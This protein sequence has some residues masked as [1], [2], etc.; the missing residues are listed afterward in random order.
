M[1]VEKLTKPG[2]TVVDL[3]VGTG[4]SILAAFHTGRHGYG[5]DIN[6]DLVS[7]ARNVFRK[8]I[9]GVATAAEGGG[10]DEVVP[11][12]TPFDMW[13]SA[14]ETEAQELPPVSDKDGDQ[15]PLLPDDENVVTEKSDESSDE[16]AEEAADEP[17]DDE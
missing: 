15:D 14:M 11:M 17:S 10:D 2:G 3:T 8:I 16:A 7:A 5:I 9:P 13:K 12:V 4:A 1:L 6:K